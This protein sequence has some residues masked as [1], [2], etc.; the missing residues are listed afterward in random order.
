MP[1]EGGRGGCWWEEEG[2]TGD[3]TAEDGT[4]AGECHCC[5]WA[6][7]RLELLS[8]ALLG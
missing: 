2:V 6:P 4:T 5:R 7:V 1:G 8:W 3:G